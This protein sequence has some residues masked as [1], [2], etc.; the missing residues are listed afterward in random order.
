MEGHTD[1]SKKNRTDATCQKE[2]VERVNE[3]RASVYLHTNEM[4]I[5]TEGSS[6]EMVHCLPLFAAIIPKQ[7]VRRKL[8]KERKRKRERILIFE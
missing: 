2:I 1:R 7:D 6:Q 4:N 3:A 5:T 8:Q